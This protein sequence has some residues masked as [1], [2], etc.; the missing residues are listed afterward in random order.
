MQC[1]LPTTLFLIMALY[2]ILRQTAQKM[3]KTE[4]T[5]IFVLGY[6]IFGT[7]TKAM[8]K[9]VIHPVDSGSNHADNNSDL[10]PFLTLNQQKQNIFIN[11][12]RI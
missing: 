1:I 10:P 6:D 3:L 7:V 11:N 5:P 8:M 4:I 12:T 9:K 2:T